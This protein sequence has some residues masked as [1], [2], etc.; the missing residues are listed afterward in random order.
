MTETVNVTLTDVP[1]GAAT[2]ALLAIESWAERMYS[3]RANDPHLQQSYNDLA[4][5]VLPLRGARDAAL[6]WDRA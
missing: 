6:I 1:V 4:A 3:D 5:I 2:D